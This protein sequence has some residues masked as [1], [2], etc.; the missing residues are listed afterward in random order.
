MPSKRKLLKQIKKLEERVQALEARPVYYWPVGRP[1]VPSYPYWPYYSTDT[2]ITS[3]STTFT[4]E[5]LGQPF[6]SVLDKNLESMYE[7]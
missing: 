5:P 3:G 6:Q 7:N 4:T 2:Q 1:Y